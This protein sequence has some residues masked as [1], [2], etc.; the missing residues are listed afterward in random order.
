MGIS[1]GISSIFKEISVESEER[2]KLLD[3]D[4]IVCG[5]EVQKLR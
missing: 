3:V 1:A 4:L 2:T 5:A